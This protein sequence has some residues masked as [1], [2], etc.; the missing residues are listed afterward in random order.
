ME[1]IAV[2]FVCWPKSELVWR[3]LFKTELRLCFCEWCGSVVK[4]VMGFYW[5][6]W[7]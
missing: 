2:I 6:T 4:V 1:W 5:M 3:G 7:V